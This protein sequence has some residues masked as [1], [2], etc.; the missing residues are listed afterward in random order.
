MDIDFRNNSIKQNL[1]NIDLVNRNASK[2]KL[3]IASTASSAVVDRVIEAGFDLFWWLPLVDDPDENRSLTRRMYEATKLP[4]LNTGG[5]V[6]TAAWVFAQFWLEIQK[7]A[8]IGMD[9]GYYKDLP[10]EMTQGYHELVELLGKDG[11]TQEYFPVIK[12]ALTREEFYCDPTYF[13]YRQNLLELVKNSSSTIYNCTEGGTLFGE[14]VTNMY[15]NDFLL[16][17]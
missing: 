4:A 15:F 11:L 10:Y 16:E 14:G 5:N 17:E 2:S 3:I 8:V 1:N 7:V 9:L 12:N 13:W 6:G